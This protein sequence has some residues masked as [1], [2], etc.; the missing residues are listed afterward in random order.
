[1]MKEEFE[2]KINGTVS[3]EDYAIVETVYTWH[4]MIP[5]VDGKKRIAEL[6]KLGGMGL[7]KDMWS[8]AVEME[9][10]DD[11]IR[12][13]RKI[14]LEHEETLGECMKKRAMIIA[15]YGGNRG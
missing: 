13:E 11:C 8:K 14:I 6:Y 15:E 3:T 1:M 10:L 7:M 2:S 12:Q 5:E 9:G 4:P